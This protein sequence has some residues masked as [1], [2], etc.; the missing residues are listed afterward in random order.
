MAGGAFAQASDLEPLRRRIAND[1]GIAVTSGGDD[2]V[3][4]EAFMLL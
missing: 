3:S 2:A 4:R 1:D